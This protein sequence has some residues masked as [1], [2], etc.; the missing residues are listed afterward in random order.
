M[1]LLASLCAGLGTLDRVR[2]V[3]KTVGLVQCAG[4]FAAQPAVISRCSGLLAAVFGPEN[5]IGARSERGAL[6]LPLGAAVEIELIVEIE[7]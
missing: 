3:V 4:D 6:A 1:A 5:G 7:P 2:C